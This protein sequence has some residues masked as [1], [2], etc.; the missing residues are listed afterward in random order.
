MA[1]R[2]NGGGTSRRGLLWAGLALLALVGLGVAVVASAGPL[3]RPMVEARAS[4]ALGRPVSIGRLRI[5]L[6][7]VTT[8]TADD[9][10]IGN[11]PDF[12][13]RRRP[14]SRACRV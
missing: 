5:A 2:R 14:G 13:P 11:Q 6:G 9:V 4:A 7:R 12:R 1:A 3:L 10:T 8:I